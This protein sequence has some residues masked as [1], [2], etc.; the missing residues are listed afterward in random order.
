M[1][2]AI[3]RRD[4]LDVLALP[5]AVRLLILDSDIREVDLVVEVRQVMFVC[6]LANL[7]RRA[8]G[9]AVVVVAVAV[10]LVKPALI[11]AL[12]LVVED[13]AIDVRAALL[14]PRLGLFV[15]AIDLDVVL[16]LAV[17]TRPE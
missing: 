9:V 17:R 15:R 14:E 10:V 7:I 6:P 16:Q 5:A 4:D 12:E 8:I 1:G 13:D 11:L 3:V 2:A